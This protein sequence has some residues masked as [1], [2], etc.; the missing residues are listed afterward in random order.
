MQLQSVHQLA[1]SSYRKVKNGKTIKKNQVLDLQPGLKSVQPSWFTSGFA[2][3]CKTTCTNCELINP[4]RV[5]RRCWPSG[6]VRVIISTLSLVAR[7]TVQCNWVQSNII[8]EW[9]DRSPC[10]WTATKCSSI[11]H[12][13]QSQWHHA[14]VIGSSNLLN[15]CVGDDAGGLARSQTI[16]LTDNRMKCSQEGSGNAYD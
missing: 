4:A 8:R 10:R 13:N 16:T 12:R 6:V 3:N 7:S 5:S 2:G 1:V 15:I 11:G 14:A 9:N